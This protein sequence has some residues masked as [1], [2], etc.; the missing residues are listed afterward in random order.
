MAEVYVEI[1][2]GKAS[3]MSHTVVLTLPATL[4]SHK[5]ARYFS[6]HLMLN[7]ASLALGMRTIE[8]TSSLKELLVMVLRWQGGNRSCIEWAQSFGRLSLEDQGKLGSI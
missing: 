5:R 8:M 6:F 4:P 3:V 1:T 7:K 2:G